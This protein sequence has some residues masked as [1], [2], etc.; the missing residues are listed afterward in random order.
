MPPVNAETLHN[1]LRAMQT[2]IESRVAKDSRLPPDQR[3]SNHEDEARNQLCKAF[4]ELV[5]A[6]IEGR[7]TDE[8]WE[9]WDEMQREQ[10][11]QNRQN[12]SFINSLVKLIDKLKQQSL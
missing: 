2:Y 1:L 10:L 7:L 9:S 4:A 11:E 12:L 5:D 6:R 8:H 3:E